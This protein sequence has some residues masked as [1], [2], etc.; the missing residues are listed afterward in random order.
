MCKVYTYTRMMGWRVTENW[1][2][3]RGGLGKQREFMTDGSKQITGSD[4]LK[5]IVQENNR[6]L[7]PSTTK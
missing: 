3:G 1:S 6:V 4:S 5:S 2:V 7:F